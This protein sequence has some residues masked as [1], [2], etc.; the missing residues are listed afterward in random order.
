MAITPSCAFST[1]STIGWRCFF[2]RAWAE[3]RPTV[4][5]DRP[6]DDRFAVYAGSLAGYGS[7]GRLR[8]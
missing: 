2:Y 4:Q 3:A 6:D 7:P 1:F 8:P 5:H